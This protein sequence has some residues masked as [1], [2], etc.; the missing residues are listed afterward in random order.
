MATAYR[1]QSGGQFA[2][3][4]DGTWYGS[5]SSNTCSM[6]NIPIP[7]AYRKLIIDIYST[8]NSGQYNLSTLYLR[9]AY[10][11]TGYYGGNFAGN[12]LKTVQF[13]NYS[14]SVSD[15]N[16]QEGVEMNATSVFTMNRQKVTVDIS[17][18]ESDMFVGW[19]RCDNQ[20]RLYSITAVL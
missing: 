15:L 18:I 8:G 1:N 9:D 19:H 12:N 4:A 6:W 13:T 16:N 2:L 20:T 10:G 5:Q 17:E 7:A 3:Q 14:S 11:V